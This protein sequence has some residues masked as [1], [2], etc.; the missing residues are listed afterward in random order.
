VLIFEAAL[1]LP[2]RAFFRNLM[3]IVV[4]AVV[5]LPSPRRSSASR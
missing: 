2:T 5:A 4:L 1:G 3:P